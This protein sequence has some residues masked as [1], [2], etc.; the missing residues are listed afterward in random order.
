MDATFGIYSHCFDPCFIYYCI[1]FI[2]T[3][4]MRLA[5]ISSIL[6]AILWCS[7][8]C[9]HSGRLSYCCLTPNSNKIKHKIRRFN[10]KLLLSVISHFSSDLSSSYLRL[11][12]Q[13]PELF[14]RISNHWEVDD[15][16]VFWLVTLEIAKAELCQ[17][18]GKCING[19]KVSNCLTFNA[20][21]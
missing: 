3:A 9:S 1:Y 2:Y 4:W 11:E 6:A 15:W 19:V 21:V 7:K 17:T 8:S 10:F 16:E 13:I 12:F 18:Q 5:D 20:L 14:Q